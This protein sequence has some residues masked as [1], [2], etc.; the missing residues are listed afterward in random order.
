[1]VVPTYYFLISILKRLRVG[2]LNGTCL[3]KLFKKDINFYK[4]FFKE[5]FDTNMRMCFHFSL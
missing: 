2:T 3:M 4:T 5:F 1:M